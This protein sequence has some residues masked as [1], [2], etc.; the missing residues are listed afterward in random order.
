M[1]YGTLLFS[2][3]PLSETLFRLVPGFSDFFSGLYLWEPQENGGEAS[4]FRK[5]LLWPLLSTL[6]Y[7]DELLTNI[8]RFVWAYIQA[9]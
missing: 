3:S 4:S 1:G 6:G 8:R 2:A 7:S 5:G 9:V